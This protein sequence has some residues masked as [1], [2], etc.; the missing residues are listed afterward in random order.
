M[1][2]KFKMEDNKPISTPMITR[3]KLSKDDESMEEI[4]FI[5]L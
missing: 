4:F 3:S 1:L 2:N 5:D